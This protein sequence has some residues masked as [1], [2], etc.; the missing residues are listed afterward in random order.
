MNI[1]I[2]GGTGFLGRPLAEALAR[3]GHQ[4]VV[5]TRQASS[6]G[7]VRRVTWQPDGSIGPWAAEVDGAGAVINLAGESIAGRRW[8]TAHK[9]R[10]LESRVLVTKSLTEAIRRASPPPAVLISGSAV[11]YYGPLD[12]RVATEDTPAGHDFLASV[13]VKWETEAMQVSSLIRVVCL[14]TGLVLERDGGALPPM[15]TPFWFGA[16]GPVGSGRQFWPWIHR[17]DWIDL[18]RFAVANRA[19][20]GPMNATAPHPV[21]NREFAKALGRAMH[22]PAFMPAPEVALKL[23]MGEMAEALVLSG[24]RAIPEKAKRLGFTFTYDTLDAA[25]ASLFPRRT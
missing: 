17:Q 10:V 15:L 18:V 4:V 1:V 12:D 8:S 3:D 19:C 5:L 24:Q 2:S 20:I 16:G 23:M 6:P 21:M 7:P 14:R 13:C 22:R 9:N 11:G 25:L